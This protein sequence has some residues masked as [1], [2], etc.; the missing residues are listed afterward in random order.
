MIVDL[1][2]IKC[3]KNMF[4]FC[5]GNIIKEVE[6]HPDKLKDLRYCVS[7]EDDGYYYT[8]GMWLEE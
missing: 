7:L 6:D 4:D 3:D 1:S 8:K 5:Y 2:A